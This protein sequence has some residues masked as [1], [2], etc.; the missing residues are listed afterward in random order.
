MKKMS[1]KLLVSSRKTPNLKSGSISRKNISRKPIVTV[2]L[3]TK[4]QY[5]STENGEKILKEISKANL[6]QA[7]MEAGVITAS[8]N[9]TAEYL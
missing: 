9:L 1:H 3:S 5:T 4:R 7:A 6:R 2:E 8:G